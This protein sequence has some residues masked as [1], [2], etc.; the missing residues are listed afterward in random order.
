METWAVHL[1]DGTNILVK[2][3]HHYIREGQLHFRST[4]LDSGKTETMAVFAE[5]GWACVQRIDTIPA[6]REAGQC[7]CL[8]TK[9][10]RGM[11]IDVVREALK[12]GG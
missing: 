1:C 11:V 8:Y 12:A 10:F 9:D 4:D 5:M 2:T 3:D 6:E 7:D